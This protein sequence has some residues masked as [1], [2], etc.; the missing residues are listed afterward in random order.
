[1]VPLRIAR[2][3]WC[4]NAGLGTGKPAIWIKTA[5]SISSM[6]HEELVCLA[7]PTY[8]CNIDLKMV[9]ETPT[10]YAQFMKEPSM[11]SNYS[12]SMMTGDLDIYSVV[13]W[14]DGRDRVYRAVWNENIN[15]ELNDE[16]L[17]TGAIAFPR[18]IIAVT[19]LNNDGQFDIVYGDSWSSGIAGQRQLLSNDHQVVNWLV[20]DYDNDGDLDILA[21]KGVYIG[22]FDNIDGAGAFSAWKRIG[23]AATTFY[24]E[25]LAGDID[26]DGDTDL[27][28]V[29]ATGQAVLFE[30]RVTGDINNDGIFN[31]ADLVAAF[32]HGEYED[33][34]YRN[35]TFLAGDW[36]GDREFDTS[37]LV[38]AFQSGTYVAES[39]PPIAVSAL[40]ETDT[41]RHPFGVPATAAFQCDGKHVLHAP[42]HAKCTRI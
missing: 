7:G 13:G 15:G 24:L 29:T 18:N 36:N 6:R 4:R 16:E 12:M 9:Q 33:G 2:R 37:D 19:D 21:N 3:N 22:W 26:N 10:D 32:I 34:V 30:Q 11:S 23:S 1:M 8:L 27:M 17:L 14:E 39:V 42:R 38:F 40:F 25:R 41:K 28:F 35:S 5:V 31:S 20:V